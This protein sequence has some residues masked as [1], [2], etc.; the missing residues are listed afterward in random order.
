M[1][2]DFRCFKCL[3]G[4]YSIIIRLMHLELRILAL[5][6]DRLR[7]RAAR[8]SVGHPLNDD[9]AVSDQSHV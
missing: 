7:W 4:I 9:V 5:K 2:L 6:E 1:R 3:L 8:R